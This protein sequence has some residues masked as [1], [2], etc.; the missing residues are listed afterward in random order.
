MP[1]F[2]SDYDNT[3]PQRNTPFWRNPWKA[4]PS[5]LAAVFVAATALDS[6]NIIDQTQLGID[7]RLGKMITDSADQLRT[8]GL[9]LKVPFITSIKKVQIDLQQRDY[10]NVVTYTKD[11][12][13]I[14]AKLSVFLKIPAEEIVSIY[15]NNPAWESKLETTVADSFKSA[16]GKQEAQNVAFNRDAIMKT[17]TEEVAHDVR[18][19]LGI[20]ITDVKM[21]NFDFDDDFEKAVGLA[22]NEKAVLERK[23]T[24]LEQ[25]RVDKDKAVVTAEG[26]ALAEKEAAG[27][28]AFRIEAEAKAQA[29][30]ELAKLKAQAEGF[31]QVADA[32]GKENMGTYLTTNKWKGDVPQ[33]SGGGGTIVDLRQV[34]PVATAPAPGK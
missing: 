23:R 1:R 32:V 8:P 13:I 18:A 11:N 17:V 29:N 26:K 31:Q 34:A 25:S 19:L 15:R 16:L 4:G 21:P 3:T 5:A 33:V 7:Y 2:D 28:T 20:N 30:G 27:A 22:A 12:Q 6:F 10:D 14:D 24:E 9:N